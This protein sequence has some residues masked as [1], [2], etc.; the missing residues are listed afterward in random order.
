MTREQRSARLEKM[1]EMLEFF[2]KPGELGQEPDDKA[3][4][5]P[6]KQLFML[7]LLERSR[8]DLPRERVQHAIDL[9]KQLE[10]QFDRLPSYRH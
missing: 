3:L 8:G 1:I 10:P 6:L 9:A 2:Q 5:K 7:L 4:L